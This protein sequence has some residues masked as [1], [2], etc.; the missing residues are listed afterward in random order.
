[1]R[2]PPAEMQ[3]LR[4]QP[5]GLPSPKFTSVT[6]DYDLG[7]TGLLP[8]SILTV[9]AVFQDSTSGAKVTGNIAPAPLTT[10]SDGSFG[11]AVTPQNT[12]VLFES[13]TLAPETIWRQRLFARG[14]G[15]ASQCFSRPNSHNG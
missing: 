3:R 5:F 15:K 1:M 4:V 13:G 2:G 10:Q 12:T 11:V 14:R 7:G 8:N 6:G 9:K